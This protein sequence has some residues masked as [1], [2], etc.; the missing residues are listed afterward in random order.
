MTIFAFQDYDLLVISISPDP[1][2]RNALALH[3]TC[4][5]SKRQPKGR[6]LQSARTTDNGVDRPLRGLIRS[7]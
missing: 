3:K 2:S 6:L 1:V 4:R 5:Q 7:S